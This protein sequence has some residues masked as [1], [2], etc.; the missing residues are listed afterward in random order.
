MIFIT[1][2]QLVFCAISLIAFSL[3]SMIRGC[4]VE[5]ELLVTIYWLFSVSY[6]L[7]VTFVYFSWLARI[8]LSF[9]GSVY[10]NKPP[11]HTYFVYA[12]LL[13][14][15]FLINILFNVFEK[16]INRWIFYGL[17]HFVSVALLM[18]IIAL[19]LKNLMAVTAMSSQNDEHTE[20][21]KNTIVKNA[22][23][24][25]LPSIITIFL[26]LT[27]MICGSIDQYPPLQVIY[28]LML[29]NICMS[30][31]CLLWS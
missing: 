24:G 1:T 2:M 18:H 28:F 30:A 29:F 22:L 26:S 15:G 13:I 9:V 16:P 31:T 21:L 12:A 8:R 11:R 20:K 17:F 7:Q 10:E 3:L 4:V 5:Q 27:M 14:I 23:L 6:A 25:F 19:F